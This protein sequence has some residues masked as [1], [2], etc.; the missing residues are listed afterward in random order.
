MDTH[1]VIV[2]PII[3]EKSMTDAGNG[4]FTFV[5]RQNASKDMIKKAVEKKFDVHVISLTTTVTK[6][7]TKRVGAR[8]MEKRVMQT[9]KAIVTLKKG[10]KISL[11]SLSE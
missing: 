3:T 5:V 11:F 7:K 4:R 2:K 1:T 6:G 9:K 10:E 8:R